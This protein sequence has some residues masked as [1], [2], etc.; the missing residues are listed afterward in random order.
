MRKKPVIFISIMALIV[1][2]IFVISEIKLRKQS[3]LFQIKL[4]STSQV[5]TSDSSQNIEPKVNVVDLF[6]LDNRRNSKFT[7]K[8]TLIEM[9]LVSENGNELQIELNGEVNQSTQ[10]V[11]I[12]GK[13]VYIDTFSVKIP[14]NTNATMENCSIVFKF[15][16]ESTETVYAGDFAFIDTSQIISS[17]KIKNTITYPITRIINGYPTIVGFILEIT[18]EQDAVLKEFDFRL[19]KYGV[20][21]NKIVVRNEPADK[22]IE[23]FEKN[24]LEQEFPGITTIEKVDKTSYSLD[25]ILIKKG[26]NTIIIPLT[27]N[28]QGFIPPIINFGGVLNYTIDETNYNYVIQDMKYLSVNILDNLT[29]KEILLNGK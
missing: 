17:D 12:D 9:K 20:N 16:D 1:I 26:I 10:P 3:S 24:E 28:E 21:S 23:L 15:R 8:D 2:S 4:L 22:Y 19:P 27:T 6:L 13:Q 18:A 7:S 25:D 5:F 14:F 11:D 29:I